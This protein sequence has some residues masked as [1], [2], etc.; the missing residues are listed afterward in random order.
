MKVRTAARLSATF[1]YVTP[2]ARHSLGIHL[3]HVADG[4][5]FD[6]FG[7]FTAVNF[8]DDFVLQDGRH[9]KSVATELGLKRILVL[10]VRA[11]NDADVSVPYAHFTG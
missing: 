7:V 2:I 9:G 6:N 8:L 3:A 11:F 4:G 1:P 10:E 5:Y